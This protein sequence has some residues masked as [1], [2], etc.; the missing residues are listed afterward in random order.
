MIEMAP[1]INFGNTIR[2]SG[3]RVRLLSPVVPCYRQL[4]RITKIFE[5]SLS[6][7]VL[8]CSLLFFAACSTHVQRNRELRVDIHCVTGNKPEFT[9]WLFDVDPATGQ[10]QFVDSEAIVGNEACGSTYAHSVDLRLN[11]MVTKTR[12]FDRLD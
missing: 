5:M 2:N 4:C 8:C 12:D 9:T 7:V 3:L 1:Q 11:E 10:R 6:S